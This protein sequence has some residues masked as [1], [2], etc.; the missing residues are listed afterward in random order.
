MN[1]CEL[2]IAW[3]LVNKLIPDPRN[4]RTHS[5]KQIK[6]LA[7]SI[8][9]FGFLIP[10]LVDR[11]GNIIAGHARLLA[12]KELDMEKVPVIQV[13]HLTEAQKRAYIIADNRL[14]EN[15]GW[16]ENLLRVELEYLSQV[17]I[18]VDVDL[19]GFEI[20]E[21]D[22]IIGNS[23]VSAG[24]ELPLPPVPE[25]EDTVTRPGDLWQL[26]VHQVLCGDSREESAVSRLMAGSLASMII[27]DP[28][29]NVRVDGH[30]GGLGKTHH[31]E[32]AMAS[33]EMSPK[34]FIAFLIACLTQL[35]RVSKVGSLHYIFMDWRHMPEL[36]AA[37]QEV[38]DDMLNLCVWTK[39]N[40]GMGSLY[41][42]QHELVFIFKHGTASHINNVALG[43]YGRYRT[44]VWNYAGVNAFG[45]GRDEALAM[46]PTVK[47]VQMIADAIL[48]VTGQGDIVLDGFLGSGTTVLAA[49][50]T[51]RVCYGVEFD[52]RYVDLALRRWIDVTG[53]QPVHAETGQTFDQLAAARLQENSCEV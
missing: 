37:G 16:D 44:N 42:S 50:Q 36:L 31:P 22:L 48:D 27:T 10:I 17:D 29:Y 32:F 34:E 35:A 49:E 11:P 18:D 12:A 9:A 46:H 30:V 38:Y 41:R 8:K 15:A 45:K 13:E 40:G 47:P 6:Q 4:A 26:G 3:M 39:T 23:I 20:P 52:P 5:R 33:G 25:I 53:E 21:I 1:N 14:A 51:G 28:P 2:V 43:K 24:D 19:T 7:R